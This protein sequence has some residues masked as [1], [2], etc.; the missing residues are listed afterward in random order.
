MNMQ[1]T[2]IH[3][4]PTRVLALLL[5]ALV[6]M[7]LSGCPGEDLDLPVPDQMPA[8][9]Q[10]PADQ[11]VTAGGTASFNVVASNGATF[12]WQSFANGNW[13][14]IPGATSTS[15]NVS[16]ATQGQSGTQYRVLVSA[17]AATVVSSPATLTVTVVII[18][19]SITVQPADQTVTEPA[20]ATFNVTAT[21]SAPLTYQWQRSTSGA[22][23]D[24]AGATSATYVT[25]ATVRASDNAAQ[26]RVQVTNSAGTAT[27]NA[28]TL[29][30]NPAPVAPAF[31][32]QPAD[33][34][35]TAP[36]TATFTV[37]ATGTPAPTLQWQ[38]STDAGGTW[39]NV[40]TGTGAITT[41][42]VTEATSTLISGRLYRAVA[43]NSAGSANSNAATL[44][45]NPA[46]SA[47]VIT[48]SPTDA[49][50]YEPSAATFNVAATGTPSPT[51]QWQRSN[52]LGANWNNIVGATSGAYTTPATSVAADNDARFRAVVQNVAGTATTGAAV[53]TVLTTVAPVITT[54]PS[55][56]E[57]TGGAQISYT[58]AA[59]GAP[60]PSLQW[61]RSDDA[62]T[63]WVEIPGATTGTYSFNPLRADDGAEF[64]AV[65][66]NTA[67]VA[68]SNAARFN[69]LAT[70][71]ILTSVNAANGGAS[72]PPFQRFNGAGLDNAGNFVFTYGNENNG[73]TDVIRTI[74]PTTGAV[75]DRAT[76][77][78]GL[79]AN[80]IAF[81]PAGN[82]YVAN[83][84]RVRMVD[85]GGVQSNFSSGYNRLF[86]GIAYLGGSL[87]ATND[88]S[89]I[90]QAISVPG[91]VPTVIAGSPGI[92]NAQSDGTGSNARFQI[93]TGLA[94]DSVDGDLYV[95][96]FAGGRLV[97][98]TT[99]GTVTTL[100]S[101]GVGSA[102]GDPTRLLG[103][104]WLT[105]DDAGNVYYLAGVNVYKRK[106]NGVTANVG[107]LPLSTETRILQ[108]SNSGFLAVGNGG[109][110]VRLD[111]R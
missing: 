19:P 26:Y 71:T 86:G 78:T 94:L 9:S 22:F 80:G 25:P 73:G 37:A 40:S 44:T 16:N 8:I 91:A 111:L 43:T 79:A 33:I 84:D 5:L 29:A 30:V 51:F 74:V 66:T 47:P 99:S 98:V 45:V 17:G 2:S 12:Q 24:V 15:Y 102:F 34:T 54:H 92:C 68:N 62:G 105:S 49:T 1:R 85:T 96:D 13:T 77:S 88:A 82:M 83:Y 18:A 11:S 109:N 87:Y 76:I 95:C 101:S 53:L 55:F 4:A 21:G 23:A 36:A 57:V 50:V 103:C 63:T 59:S 27:S 107:R 90:V 93:P 60:T 108:W 89:C 69:N 48:M 72:T 100:T 20:T 41:T 110:L 6:V 58:A 65:A 42:Y 106:P 70:T 7:A 104:D 75:S 35:V 39:S 52:D 46:P 32:T 10:Q 31:T 14:N 64:R 81:D 97:S 3:A 67:G 38:A 61:Q 28:A 56:Q